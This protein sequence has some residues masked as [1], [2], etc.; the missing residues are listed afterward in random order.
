MWFYMNQ[1]TEETLWE[2]TSQGYTK[3]DG[4]LVLTSGQVSLPF[5]EPL[6]LSHDFMTSDNRR[7][8][9]EEEGSSIERV[10]RPH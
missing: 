9:E 1:K 10:W 4:M 2:P 8:C 7:S 6:G 5:H 3:Y